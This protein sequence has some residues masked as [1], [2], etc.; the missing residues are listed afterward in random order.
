LDD[1]ELQRDIAKCREYAKNRLEFARVYPDE[2]ER[3]KIS[4]DETAAV[5]EGIRKLKAT[6]PTNDIEE[7]TILDRIRWMRRTVPTQIETGDCPICLED[8]VTVCV[9]QK[10][11]HGFCIKCTMKVS[12]TDAKYL[13]YTCPICRT[14]GAADV[15]SVFPS[16]IPSAAERSESA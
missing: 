7:R 14:K 11:G 3:M 15:R 16:G 4:R 9:F 2:F 1:D 13:Y 6:V 10:C 8:N 12:T 5:I